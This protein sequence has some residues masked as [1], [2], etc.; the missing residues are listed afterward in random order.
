[1]QSDLFDARLTPIILMVVDVSYGGENGFNQAGPPQP[2]HAA[3]RSRLPHC[4]LIVCMYTLAAS[5]SLA[6]PLVAWL[7]AHRVHVHTRRLLL[8]GLTTGSVCSL[9]RASLR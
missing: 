2:P 7:F 1:M 9:T 4:S 6:S 3:R 8:P 5:S